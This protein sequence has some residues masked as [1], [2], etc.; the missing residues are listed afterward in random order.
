MHRQGPVPLQ[1]QVQEA[2]SVEEDQ[3]QAVAPRMGTPQPTADADVH[4]VDDAEAHDEQ[5]RNR[6]E[7]SYLMMS[8]A[9][10][11]LIVF[12]FARPSVQLVRPSV[13]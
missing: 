11:H 7:G 6:P 4:N 12:C 3:G 9:L 13:F 1:H 10:T 8:V 5:D 2:Q